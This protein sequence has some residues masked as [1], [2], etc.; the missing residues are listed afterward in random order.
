MKEEK[1]I[2]V[3]LRNKNYAKTAKILNIPKSKVLQTMR[4]F[5]GS[6]FARKML[7]KWKM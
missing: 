5:K 2:F 6:E 7:K 3:F 4:N 1:I